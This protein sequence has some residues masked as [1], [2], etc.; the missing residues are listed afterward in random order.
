MTPYMDYST[1]DITEEE[2]IDIA[3]GYNYE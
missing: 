3:Q 2:A 1:T